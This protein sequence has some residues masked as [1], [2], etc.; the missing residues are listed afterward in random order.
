MYR[1]TGSQRHHAIGL[2]IALSECRWTDM[3]KTYWVNFHV[4][5]FVSASTMVA[6]QEVVGEGL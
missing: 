2:P 3:E 4:A 5:E 1:E 6:G